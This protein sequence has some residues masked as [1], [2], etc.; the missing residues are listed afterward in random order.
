MVKYSMG[1]LTILC[2]CAVSQIKS[3]P[4][5]KLMKVMDNMLAM[6]FEPAEP[7]NSLEDADKLDHR[8]S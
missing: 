1:V 5:V 8:F 7:P 2:R 6:S 4:T 3:A